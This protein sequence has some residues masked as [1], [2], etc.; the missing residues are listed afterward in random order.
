[1][2]NLL[3]KHPRVNTFTITTPVRSPVKAKLLEQLGVKTAI[4]SLDEPDKLIALA[5]TAD[6]VF[7]IVS[8]FI[9]D[10]DSSQC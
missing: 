1:M 6:V 4:A 7:N 9:V 5:S 10:N 3:L 2:L 8:V